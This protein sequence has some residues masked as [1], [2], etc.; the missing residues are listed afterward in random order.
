MGADAVRR[1]DVRPAD[2]RERRTTID[3]DNAGTF[4][5][6]LGYNLTPAFGVEFGYGHTTANLNAT[7]YK[8]SGGGSGKIGHLASDS[9][10]LDGLWHWGSPR[11]SGYVLLGGGVMS[12]NPSVDGAA[13]SSST[14]F[15]WSLGIGGKFSITPNAAIRIEGRFRD[16]NLGNTTSSGVWCDYYY[17]YAYST[18]WYASGEITGGLTFRFGK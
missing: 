16:T 10:E 18:S 13:T 11:A 8:P 6:R 12:M 9:F 17:C 15:T 2:L 14:N 7:N 3:V 4:G 5:G 1:R